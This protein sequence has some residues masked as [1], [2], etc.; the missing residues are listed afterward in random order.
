MKIITNV[1]LPTLSAALK[2]V[3]ILFDEKI[4]KVSAD[5]IITEEEYETIDGKGLVILPGAIDPHTHILGD[6]A[7]AANDLS[8]ISKAA[9]EGGWT[10][11]AELSYHTASPIFSPSDLNKKIALLNDKVWTNMALWGH[12][13]IS[14]YPYHAEAAQELWSKG[15]VGIALAAPS[16][17]PAISEIS[18]TEIMD[19]FLD[20]YESDTAF[21]FQG[22]DHEAYPEYSFSSQMDAI[23]KLLRRM[24]E[25]PIHIPRVSSYVTM[26]F[27]GAVSKRSD[28]SFATCISDLMPF[29]NPEIFKPGN[30]CDF[31]EYFDL[32]FELIRTNKIY[33]LSNCVAPPNRQPVIPA[34]AGI[35]NN[36]FQIESGMTKNA[37]GE[38]FSGSNP[39]TLA[40]SYLWVL[41]ELWKQRKVPL[42]TCI[43]MTSENAAK[44]MGIYPQKGSLDPGCDADF[45]L[46]N[47]ELTS[48]FVSP[49]GTKFQLTGGFTGIYLGGELVAGTGV[50]TIRKGSFLARSSN[51]KRRHN[52]HTWI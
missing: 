19:L 11:L 52:H 17:N 14:D 28:I 44:R 43:K 47:P 25:N 3:N 22:Y 24:Q 29:L 31:S 4:I 45:V 30:A 23:K 7:S 35:Q 34:K 40:Y 6:D 20:I 1:S 48:S 8:S 18:F 51:P 16:P 36:G 38:V 21:A 13:D 49:E 26:E 15:I 39:Q 12:V 41:S 37:F 33:L 2:R 27:I 46:Y 32:L 5:E 42:A 10:T 50:D 9:L